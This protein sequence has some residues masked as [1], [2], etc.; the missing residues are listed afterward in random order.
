MAAVVLLL[1]A[2]LVLALLAALTIS[3][4]VRLS[5]VTGIAAVKTIAAT[6]VNPAVHTVTYVQQQQLRVH[7]FAQQAGIA[8]RVLIP[9]VIIRQLME[10]VV[11][12][13]MIL[14][15]P[16]RFVLINLGKASC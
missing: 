7:A 6:I 12:A 2:P 14:A 4:A 15:K 3:A 11:P 8:V 10:N 16:F 1:A 13:R 9:V 5:L